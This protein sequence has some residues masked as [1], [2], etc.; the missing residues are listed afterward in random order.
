MDWRRSTIG[1]AI[2]LPVIALLAFGMTRDPRDI[3]SPLPGR[4]APD[5]TLASF[6]SAGTGGAKAATACTSHRCAETSSS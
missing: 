5:F 3:P 6:L 4:E 1:A 2:A